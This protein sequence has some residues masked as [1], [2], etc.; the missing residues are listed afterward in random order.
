MK[1]YRKAFFRNNHLLYVLTVL[2][3]VANTAIPLFVSWLLGSIFDVILSGELNKLMTMLLLAALATGIGF[4]LGMTMHRLKTI[5]L[6]RALAQYKS[7]VFRQISDKSISAFTHESTS[8]YLS[9][10][11]NDMVSIEENYLNR[12]ILIIYHSTL[13]VLTLGMMLFYSWELTL[14]IIVLSSL[15][16]V[17]SLLM[18]KRLTT[19]EKKVSDCNEHYVGSMK[20]LL[21]GF[22][23]IKSFKAERQA[24][25]LFDTANDTLETERQ[26]RR[27][28][29]SLLSELAQCSG[30]LV[31]FA[32]LLLAAW[33]AMRGQITAG[34]VL[35][36]TNLANFILQPINTVPPYIA[37]RRA[38]KGLIKKHAEIAQENATQR[39][40]AIEP[41]LRDAIELKQLSFAYGEEAEVLRNVNLRFESG[42]RYALVGGSGAG[43]STL[44]NLLMGASGDYTGSITLDGEEL[45]EIDTDSLYAL[46]G[47][48]GQNVFLFDDT[49]Q[50]NI[51]MFSDFPAEQVRE[52]V[53]QSGLD[54]L[55]AEKGADYPCGENGSGLSGGERQRVSI[56]R[57]LLRRTPVLLVDEATAALDAKTA[58]GVTDA[59]LKL[60]NTT[61]I[62][63]THRLEASQLRRYDEIIVLKNGTVSEQGD[64]DTL[65]ERKGQ[66]YSLYMVANG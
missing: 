55:I 57:C 59:I 64:F 41:V 8:R 29:E 28:W 46:E 45:R 38:A 58:A 21:S 66:L 10:L 48:I 30:T 63:V 25:Q 14:S 16:I 13:F 36:F 42:K 34:T 5:F 52:A 39:G 47:L 26:R 9:A 37:S 17:V 12:G 27:W 22:A 18:G 23:V 3:A 56:A 43:K 49:I 24:R 20:D 7:L 65:M 50:K 35:I 33:F 44:L 1:Q 6:R 19:Q 54:A 40:K 2:F 32:L 62:V 53:R 61:R 60:E 51:T 4:L 11:T 31:Q 15:P